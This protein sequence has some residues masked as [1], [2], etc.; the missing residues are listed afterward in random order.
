[1]YLRDGE[2]AGDTEVVHDLLVEVEVALRGGVVEHD[3]HGG[4]RGVV[5]WA[6]RRHQH[7]ARQPPPHELRAQ[8]AGR[9]LLGS[10]QPAQDRLQ[11]RLL[12]TTT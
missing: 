10:L 5:P 12:V 4:V 11:T 8:R 6:G 3:G 1:M 2:G 9:Q 7:L